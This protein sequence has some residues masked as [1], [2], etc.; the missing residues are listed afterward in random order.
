[1]WRE[2]FCRARRNAPFRLAV[3]AVATPNWQASG[4]G[5]RQRA[6]RFALAVLAAAK[7]ICKPRGGAAYCGGFGFAGG[8][9]AAGATGCGSFRV[10]SLVPILAM[11]ASSDDFVSASACER[12]ALRSAIC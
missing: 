10:S 11:S 7:L 3:L 12:L 9:G 6:A 5:D 8:L 1:M 4:A 2:G